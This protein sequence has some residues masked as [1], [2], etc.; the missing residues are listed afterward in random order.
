M[1]DQRPMLLRQANKLKVTRLMDIFLR[2]SLYQFSPYVRMLCFC[3]SIR[4]FIFFGVE[5][6]P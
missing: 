5:K 2:F 1:T 4:C 3:T 6:G